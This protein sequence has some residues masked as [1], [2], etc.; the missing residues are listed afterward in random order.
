MV[1]T[2][3][4]LLLSWPELVSPM[5]QTQPEA[6]WQ[7]STAQSPRTQ[8]REEMHLGTNGPR[9][10]PDLRKFKKSPLRK[11]EWN[12]RLN[13]GKVKTWGRGWARPVLLLP[14]HGT[15]SDYLS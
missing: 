3:P 12:L 8:S 5:G 13:H 1:E 7:G 2:P 15:V 14:Y 6:R 11:S 4:D 9:M 10:G